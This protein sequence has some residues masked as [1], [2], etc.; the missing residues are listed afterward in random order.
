MAAEGSLPIP[1]KMPGSGIP[2]LDN[3]LARREL[4]P[5]LSSNFTQEEALTHLSAILQSKSGPLPAVEVRSTWSSYL[6]MIVEPAGWEAVLLPSPLTAKALGCQE[7]KKGAVLVQVVN[8][9]EENMEVEVELLQVPENWTEDSLESRGSLLTVSVDELFPVR[10][11]KNSC[12]N[13]VPTS[14]ALDLLRFF[15]KNLWM[16]WDDDSDCPDWPKT[17][18]ATRIQLAFDFVNGSGDQETASKLDELAAQAELNRT[19][20]EEMED[21]VGLSEDADVDLD[22]KTIGELYSLHAQ[23]ERIRCEA[24]KLENPLLRQADRAL[25][26]A[27]RGHQRGEDAEPSLLLVWAKGN[28]LDLGEM[29]SKVKKRGGG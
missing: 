14:V 26:L 24:E 2:S 22:I 9:Y 18:L 25:Q 21:R 29:I 13:L 19:A 15:Y 10:E 3:T 17:H 12:F 7:G 8:M 1:V 16:P 28:I 6:E 4:P 11:Q 27:K 20:L 23:Q 5:V